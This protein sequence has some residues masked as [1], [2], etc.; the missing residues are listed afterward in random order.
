MIPLR[1]LSNSSS[2]ALRFA[3]KEVFT[4]IADVVVD[5]ETGLT[6]VVELEEAITVGTE[7][8][9]VKEVD[10]PTAATYSSPPSVMLSPIKVEGFMADEDPGVTLVKGVSTDKFFVKNGYCSA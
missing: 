6:F 7:A 9:E 1:I 2:T 5:A 10:D 3:G 4:V 8:P